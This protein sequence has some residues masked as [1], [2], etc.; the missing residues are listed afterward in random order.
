M[1]TRIK[2]VAT[3]LIPNPKPEVFHIPLAA[4]IFVPLIF[5]HPLKTP[6]C[7]PNNFCAQIYK[8]FKT[9]YLAKT[10]TTYIKNHPHTLDSFHPFV[11]D[12]FW[13]TP[14]IM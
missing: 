9:D 10:Q 6:F 5:T 7:G 11:D 3:Y 8:F 2:G 1:S 13:F 4:L 14:C 12:Y